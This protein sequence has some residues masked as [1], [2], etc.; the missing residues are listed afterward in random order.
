MGQLVTHT[1][2]MSAKNPNGQVGTQ[3]FII[4]SRNFPEA[5]GQVDSHNLVVW[6]FMKMPLEQL[7]T[8]S[9]GE[10]AESP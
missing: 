7:K 9:C 5:S 2:L 8:H 4:V 3:T 1:L 10:I 6:L